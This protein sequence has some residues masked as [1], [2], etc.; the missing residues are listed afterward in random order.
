MDKE[1]QAINQRE[2]EQEKEQQRKN[3]QKQLKANEQN[4]FEGNFTLKALIQ[5]IVGTV[6][7]SVQQVVGPH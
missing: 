6:Q 3:L 5:G 2:K 7:P 4:K 1:A